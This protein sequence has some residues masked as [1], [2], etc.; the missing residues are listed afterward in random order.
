VSV[1]F[2]G[3]KMFDERE[4]PVVEAASRTGTSRG[5]GIFEEGD[6]ECCWLRFGN[7]LGLV[8]KA[9]GDCVG[10]L[11]GAVD[12]RI[13]DITLETLSATYLVHGVG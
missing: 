7:G 9:A 4:H 2:A 10:G 5:C 12:H 11:R 6:G 13:S 1:L 8:G 3:Q